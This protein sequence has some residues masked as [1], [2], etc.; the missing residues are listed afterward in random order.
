MKKIL[1]ILFIAFTNTFVLGQKIDSSVVCI[2]GTSHNNT[3]FCNVRILDSVLNHIKPDLILEELDSSFFTT[4]SHYDTVNYPN[5][6][7]ISESSPADIASINHQKAH[8]VDVR[9]FDITGRNKFYRD[10]DFFNRQNEMIKDIYRLSLNGSLSKRNQS[11]FNLWLKSLDN[12]NDLKISN[13][14]ELNSEMLMNFL[15]I[16]E[17]IYLDKPIEIVETTDSL[18]K[19]IEFAHLQ[20]DFWIKRNDTMIKNIVYFTND[21]KRIVV[22]TGNLHRYYLINGL[23]Q[24]KGS[25]I[26]KE[27]WDF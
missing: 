1:L 5:F 10:N 6:L 4:D 3:E 27:F 21:Y 2:I 19:Y 13:L 14:K 12:V 24:T 23:K 16:Q 18:N 20:K 15:E 25:Y 22:F 11:D 26:I 9:P 7:H 8:K 17:S